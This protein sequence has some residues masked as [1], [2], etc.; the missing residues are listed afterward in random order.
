MDFTLFT[1]MVN[2]SEE[3][4][5]KVA[6]ALKDSNATITEG[7]VKSFIGLMIDTLCDEFNFNENETW[8]Q[9][10]EAHKFVNETEGDFH[11]RS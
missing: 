2:I 4:T 7:M 9:L 3:T 10:Y 1:E 8:E 5:K 11:A 6:E